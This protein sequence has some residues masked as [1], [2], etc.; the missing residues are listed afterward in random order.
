[1]SITARRA[2]IIRRGCQRRSQNRDGLGVSE[3]FLAPPADAAVILAASDVRLK[4]Y[5]LG[6]SQVPGRRDSCPN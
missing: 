4:Y 1:M 3:L 6:F 2:R 5:L